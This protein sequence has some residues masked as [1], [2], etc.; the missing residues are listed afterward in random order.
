MTEIK[1]EEMGEIMMGRKGR[2]KLRKKKGKA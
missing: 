2:E 1:E